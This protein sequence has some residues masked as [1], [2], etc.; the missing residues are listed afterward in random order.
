M[1]GIASDG[2]RAAV[3]V[4][5]LRD[6]RLIDRYGFHLENV[7]GQDTATLL[8]AFAIEYYGSAPSMPPQIVVPPDSGDTS[9]LAEFL[10]ERR[11]SRVEV[12]APA[13]GEKRR[14]Q[15]L[16]TQ[17]ARLAQSTTLS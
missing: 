2:D 14:L 16:V 3:Q 17:N 1:I 13:R 7:A 5:P 12:R 9:A 6:G 11:G 15:E 8:E 10:S 4:F